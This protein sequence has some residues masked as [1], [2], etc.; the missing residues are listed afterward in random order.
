MAAIQG[1]L[2]RAPLSA[3][4]YYPDVLFITQDAGDFKAD[5]LEPS[6]H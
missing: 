4:L 5:L 3:A 2:P 6:S 1:A